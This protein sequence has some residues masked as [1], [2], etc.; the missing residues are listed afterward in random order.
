MENSLILNG[1]RYAVS[2]V[3]LHLPPD[4]DIRMMYMSVETET[5]AGFFALW[6]Y[7]LALLEDINDLDGKRIHVKPNGETYDDDTLGTDIIGAD[8]STDVNYWSTKDT[9]YC[10]GDILVDFR[11][12]KDRT[13]R[14]HVEIALTD[15]DEDP[16]DLSPE[17]YNI[18][19]NAEFTVEVDEK[20][21]WQD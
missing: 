14:V 6:N 19:G 11:R 3:E 12:I 4:E 16:E 5:E 8:N 7:E 17:D 15:S 9:P 20:D 13:Y 10:Y 21:P 1:K 18:A 2:R